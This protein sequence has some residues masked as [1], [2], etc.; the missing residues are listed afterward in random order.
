MQWDRHARKHALQTWCV[1]AVVRSQET[2]ARCRERTRA[3]Q[4]PGHEETGVKPRQRSVRQSM[5]NRTIACNNKISRLVAWPEKL[6]YD[7]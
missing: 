2:A 3:K 6:Y 4:Q 5:F 1:A 7:N